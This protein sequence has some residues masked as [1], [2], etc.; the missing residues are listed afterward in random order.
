MCCCTFALPGLQAANPVSRERSHR[1]RA[2]Q[3]MFVAS[4]FLYGRVADDPDGNLKLT[5]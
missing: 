1:H 3:L 4:V 5:R 2:D